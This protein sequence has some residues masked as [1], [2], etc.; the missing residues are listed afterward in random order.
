MERIE[1]TEGQ[2]LSYTT[3]DGTVI[4]V[5]VAGPVE[6]IF[7]LTI[8][9]QRALT[10]R[11]EAFVRSVARNVAEAHNARV[12]PQVT[13]MDGAS[14]AVGDDVCLTTAAPTPGRPWRVVEIFHLQPSG[15]PCLRLV[16]A[17]A[18]RGAVAGPHEVRMT[19]PPSMAR[20]V[21]PARIESPLPAAERQSSGLAGGGAA[22]NAMSAPVRDMLVRA[23]ENAAGEVWRGRGRGTYPLPML[24]AAAR[25]GW[26]E[27]NHPARPAWATL[28]DAG[29]KALA[30]E[31]AGAR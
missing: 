6:R 13:D 9:G 22:A 2:P 1:I 21:P 30:R 7:T 14:I 19:A 11:N 26:L 28:T 4:I 20:K 18:A 25:R 15:A 16:R 5:S 3:H 12:A 17:S 29:R 24:R 27:L 8:N 10:H 23:S 31:L